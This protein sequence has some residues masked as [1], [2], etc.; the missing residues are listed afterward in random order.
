MFLFPFQK[1]QKAEEVLNAQLCDRPAPAA[2]SALNLNT[3]YVTRPNRDMSVAET[4]ASE[5]DTVVELLNGS[6]A[7]SEHKATPKFKRPDTPPPRTQFPSSGV[8]PVLTGV[9]RLANTPQEDTI[10][11]LLDHLQLDSAAH[12]P[13]IADIKVGV[14]A[15]DGSPLLASVRRSRGARQSDVVFNV[16]QQCKPQNESKTV[17]SD[18][19]SH[20]TS[21]PTSL[22]PDNN[23][24]SPENIMK[25]E[26]S[27]DRTLE[28]ID[29]DNILDI[30]NDVAVPTPLIKPLMTMK[31]SPELTETLDVIDRHI[32]KSKRRSAALQRESLDNNELQNQLK[33]IMAQEQKLEQQKIEIQKRL[34]EVRQ[35]PQLTPNSDN[36]L[37]FDQTA[38]TSNTVG[39]CQRATLDASPNRTPSGQ[40]E[41]DTVIAGQLYDHT[42]ITAQLDLE[43]YEAGDEISF[44]L[45]PTL[46]G[47][48]GH[49][50]RAISTGNKRRSLKR[51]S[52]NLMAFSPTLTQIREQSD[53]TPNGEEPTSRQSSVSADTT[54]KDDT[55]VSV[56]GK[57]SRNTSEQM[58][59]GLSD[60]AHKQE[61][62]VD[63]GRHVVDGDMD[64]TDYALCA[65]QY[66]TID[67][68]AASVIPA[69]TALAEPLGASLQVSQGMS[70]ASMSPRALQLQSTFIANIDC[71][72][73]GHPSGHYNKLI[74][75][76]GCKKSEV[77]LSNVY[78][79]AVKRVGGTIGIYSP[80]AKTPAFKSIDT[81]DTGPIT[82]GGL[83]EQNGITVT[84]DVGVSSL[85]SKTSPNVEELQSLLTA[86]ECPDEK[87][88]PSET[89][90]SKPSSGSAFSCPLTKSSPFRPTYQNT[91]LGTIKASVTHPNLTKTPVLQTP[92]VSSLQHSA[93][94]TPISRSSHT[95]IIT[96]VV[97]VTPVDSQFTPESQITGSPELNG[98]SSDVVSTPDFMTAIKCKLASR[99]KANIGKCE[100]LVKIDTWFV[101]N[102]LLYVVYRSRSVNFCVHV[103]DTP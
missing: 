101:V 8:L 5:R 68:T 71:V 94:V 44:M 55:H 93:H 89:S 84:Q 32:S 36:L 61:V 79:P 57:T 62:H 98:S 83:N 87:T 14:A 42:N 75:G 18:D 90:Y 13:L 69:Q 103:P 58:T 39:E 34:A 11:G 59:S 2:V 66:Y 48:S 6:K 88:S 1:I 21:S 7:N 72:K 64:C 99:K 45:P 73:N 47:A 33:L 51:E 31:T 35:S 43:M 70:V 91:T 38:E 4:P 16:S 67:K 92:K 20:T 12:S 25:S 40:A 54:L 96:S 81:P 97:P 78:T 28:S 24:S 53:T 50:L 56:R 15:N 102:S 3:T 27:V 85:T 74:H 30:S 60:S 46:T 23:P 9:T 86:A 100:D 49:G 95:A 80:D 82:T 17:H 37:K 52:I 22:S 65:D 77:V 26:L 29:L 63:N 41:N 76:L 19:A 10:A